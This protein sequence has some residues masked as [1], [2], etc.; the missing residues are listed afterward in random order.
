MFRRTLEGR[1]ARVVELTAEV[2]VVL[3]TPLLPGCQ[4][5]LRELFRKHIEFVDAALARASASRTLINACRVTPRRR[6]S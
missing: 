5:D 1:L 4:I 2:G 3:T 6:A